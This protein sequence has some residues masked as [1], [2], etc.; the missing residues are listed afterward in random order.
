MAVGT[1]D[2]L[3]LNPDRACGGARDCRLDW[4]SSICPSVRADGSTGRAP[5]DQNPKGLLDGQAI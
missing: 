4:Q 3:L 5:S 2:T 1:V